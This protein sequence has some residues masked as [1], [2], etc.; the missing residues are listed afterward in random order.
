MICSFYFSMVA[1][2]MIILPMM[3]KWFAVWRGGAPKTCH[4]TAPK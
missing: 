1:G 3:I 4:C 2:M